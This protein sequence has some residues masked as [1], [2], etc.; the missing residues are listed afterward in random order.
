MNVSRGF[1][2][3]LEPAKIQLED[4]DAYAH[5]V[6]NWTLPKHFV[7]TEMSVTIMFWTVDHL[8]ESSMA[9]EAMLNAEMSLAHTGK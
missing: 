6:T 4:L 2:H 7:L 3:L 8:L 9:V 1:V 5:V